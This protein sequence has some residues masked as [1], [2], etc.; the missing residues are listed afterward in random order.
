VFTEVRVA[1][2]HEADI[3]SARQKGRELAAQNGFRATDQTLIATAISEIARNILS[4]AGTGE[5][6]ITWVEQSGR[7]GLQVI[8][9]DQGPGIARPELAMQDGYSTA[10]SL[11][12]GLPG[13]K[14]LMDEFELS[15]AVGR[16]TTVTMRK[17]L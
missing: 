10:N 6:A 8:G 5:V 17:W 9:H 14:R 3:V 13:A 1:I 15:T 12:L 2:A 11:G 16:G 4:Y 7:R